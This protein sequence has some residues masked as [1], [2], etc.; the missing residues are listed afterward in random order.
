MARMSEVPGR[1]RKKSTPISYEILD[2]AEFHYS[3]GKAPGVVAQSS[4]P[5]GFAAQVVRVCK[6]LL[7]CYL[8][9]YFF[10]FGFAHLHFVDSGFGIVTLV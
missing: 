3:A 4:P 10:S 7:D 9:C 6:R 5:P 1:P 8:D 2:F